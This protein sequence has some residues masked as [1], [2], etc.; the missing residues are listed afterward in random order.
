MTIY[1]HCNAQITTGHS[2]NHSLTRGEGEDSQQ[3]CATTQI[4]ETIE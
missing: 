3:L 1:P 2:R 4:S